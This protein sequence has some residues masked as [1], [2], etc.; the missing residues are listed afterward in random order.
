LRRVQSI[1]YFDGIVGDDDTLLGHPSVHAISG[2]LNVSAEGLP[3]CRTIFATTTCMIHP[4]DTDTITNFQ[5]LNIVGDLR[6][7]PDPFMTEHTSL[8]ISEVTRGDVKVRVTHATV[9]DIDE[10]FSRL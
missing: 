5:T 9:L 2:I 3:T 8:D 7:D 4:S 6:Y 1:R 10:R